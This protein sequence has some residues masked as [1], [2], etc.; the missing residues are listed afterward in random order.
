M[1]ARPFR[2]IQAG[3][4]AAVDLAADV[5]A[6]LAGGGPRRLSPRFFYDAEGAALFEAICQQPEYDLCRNEH[7]ILERHARDIVRAAGHP[8]RM[9][10][11][12]SGAGVKTR[13]LL[14]ALLELG[15]VRYTP[16]DIHAGS[17]EASAARLLALYP[18]LEIE[19][20]CG[21]YNPAVGAL[22]RTD[23]PTLWIWLGSSIGNLVPEEATAFLARVRAALRPR[24]LVLI[25]FDRIKPPPVLEHA[26]DD[27]AGVTARF[28]LNLLSRI[29]RELG[30]TFALDGFVH[31]ALYD[32]RL[33]RVEMHLVSTREQVVKIEALGLALGFEAGDGIHTE[34][35]YKYT[36]A[37][38]LDITRPAGLVPAGHWT[39]PG[40]RFELA[41]FAPG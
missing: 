10:E 32:P 6:G 25:G 34:N 37:R 19:A 2:M 31:H 15:A 14:E 4:N 7:A 22:P 30:G 13:L 1:S 3:G 20:I 8:R 11:L 35:A 28:N 33:R 5:R 23:E 38:A 17:L 18:A 26:Y 24:D 36:R 40:E 12:G 29:N 39:S 41:L 16:I 9:V 21:E 27:A